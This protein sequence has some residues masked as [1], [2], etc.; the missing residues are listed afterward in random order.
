[1][2]KVLVLF[3]HPNYEK[4]RVNKVL[5]NHIKDIENVTVHDL[6][7]EY[8]DFHIDVKFEKELLNKHDVIIWH[9]PFYWYS[10]PPLMKQWIDMV[11]EFNWAYGP[12]GKALHNKIC[13]NVIT[14]G[15]SKEV[16]CSEGYNSFTVAQFLRPFEQTAN[17]CGM[18]Y[19]PPFAVM[20]THNLSDEKLENYKLNYGKLI[21]L[22]K[23]DVLLNNVEQTSFI[24]D[25][26]QL[27]NE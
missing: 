20:G 6:Y 23:S 10:C 25:Y 9:H 5:I 27:K 12:E 8:P 18:N 2:K 22:L 13:L 21:D 4:S 19:L 3:S 17:L 1:M 16:Y 7:E 26:P 15:G 14:T 24:N 11:L